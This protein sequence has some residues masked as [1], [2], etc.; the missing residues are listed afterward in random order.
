MAFFFWLIGGFIALV[1]AWGV[2]LALARL[3][4]AVLR[5]ALW[6]AVIAGLALL[7]SLLA[8]QA[9]L[10]NADFYGL[11][12]AL[13]GVP[14]ALWHAFRRPDDI[15]LSSS[16]EAAVLS[17]PA[18]PQT[19]PPEPDGDEALGAAWQSAAELLPRLGGTLADQRLAC[20]RVLHLAAADPLD[21]ELRDVALLVR[22]HVP[23]LVLRSS[24][25]FIDASADEQQ[26]L[27]SQLAAS[28]AAISDRVQSL[29]GRHRAA[30]R[31]ALEV[32]HRRVRG[33]G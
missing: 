15:P 23:E 28:L 25:L 13:V 30:K 21:P 1:F 19:P 24:E 26:E 2:V 17:N 18:L 16:A 11:G 9:G 31:D 10:A 5:A 12:V 33:E 20:A 7:A 27:E 3:L 8:E 22:R 14:L 6:L 32:H 29:I 4:L